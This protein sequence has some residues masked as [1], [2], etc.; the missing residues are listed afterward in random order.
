MDRFISIPVDATGLIPDQ[1][2]VSAV[3]DAMNEPYAFTDIFIYAHGWWTNA[4]A[5]MSE[6]SKA[7]IEF[8]KTA[9]YLPQGSI[10]QPPARS[11]G[12]GIHW[13][14]TLSEDAQSLPQL[15]QPFTFYQME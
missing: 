5:S 11:F 2:V 14:S 10:T 8:G 9:Y 1:Q 3:R 13:P 12:I 6:Y 4:N 15:F 7:L